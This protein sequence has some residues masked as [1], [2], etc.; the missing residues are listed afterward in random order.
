MLFILMWSFSLLALLPQTEM[1]LADVVYL[2]WFFSL[3]ALLPQTHITLADVVYPDL[4]L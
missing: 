4:V 2:I 3:L 1:T